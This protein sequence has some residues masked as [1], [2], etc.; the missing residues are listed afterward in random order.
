MEKDM[1]CPEMG[2]AAF[3][4]GYN[5]KF[6]LFPF[7]IRK[8]RTE[9][10]GTAK[11]VERRGGFGMGDSEQM[12]SVGSPDNAV[13]VDIPRLRFPEGRIIKTVIFAA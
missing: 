9:R 12:P 13:V 2:F 3:P 1:R 7:R 11:L 5:R 6:Q 8:R 4:F 10:M